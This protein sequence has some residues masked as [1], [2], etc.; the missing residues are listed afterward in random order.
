MR[1]FHR[2]G[3]SAIHAENGMAA[4]SHPLA[5]ATA[6]SVLKEGGNAV[7]AAIAAAA[8]LVVVEP[9]MTGI[10][11][12]C[13]VLVGEPDGT[14]H[15]LN[16]SGRAPAAATAEAYRARGLS[17][18]PEFGPL[19]ITVPGAI[20]AWEALLERFGNLSFERLFAD[21]IR[22]AE[23]GFAVHSRVASDWAR[24]APR[25]EADTGGRLHF[26]PGGRAP[27]QGER[28]RSP[29]V[30]RTLRAIARGGAKAFYD[31]P[32][33][34]EMAATVQA[35]G[36]YLAEADLAAV[37]VDW[38]SPIGRSY[39]GHEVLEIPPNGQGITAL[40]LLGLLEKL[41]VASLDPHGVAR[42][43]LEMEA[44]RLAYSV[45]DHLVADPA[46]MTVAPEHLLSDGF[47]GGLASQFDPRRR[48]EA[49]VLPAIP[50][51]STVYLSVVDR[52]R[53]AVS[54]INSVYDSFG[55]GVVMPEAGFALQN[56]GACFT[57]EA[58]HPNEIGPGKRPMHTIIPAMTTLD[59]LPA[60]SFGVMGGAYQPM[61]HAH[62][63]SNMLDFG[64]DP[65][66]ALD[67]PRLFWS[68]EDGVLEAERGI[69]S[70]A[71]AALAAMGHPIR[72]ASRPHGGGQVVRIDR[73]SGFL[74]AGSDPRK[75][76][77]ALGW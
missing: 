3:R 47:I 8:T 22:Y 10:G 11:G 9:H 31:G 50:R 73:R 62:V 45:R 66:E 1:D 21:A 4:T 30:A 63:L 61:G 70:G 74:V 69:G 28:F 14:V 12:D 19:S 53:R 71:M 32:I 16:G 5:T 37:A 39:R 56:R 2:P 57:L 65:Q 52:D 27:I 75:D 13:F 55:S 49:L 42:L 41:D 24:V 7:D 43:H 20:K 59:G 72:E 44:A 54:F 35:Q 38:V 51:A 64:M 77:C 15:G 67:H 18:V 33:A 6:L 48:N 68:E 60:I 34:R 17:A 23:D 46:A 25:L 26:L 58:G 40:I 36:G 29:G 76:G